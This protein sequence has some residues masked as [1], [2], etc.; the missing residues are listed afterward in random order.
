MRPAMKLFEVFLAPGGDPK[1][2]LSEEAQKET[3]AQIFSE[4]EAKLVGLEGL[5]ENET[6]DTRVFIACGHSDAQ[7]V[8]TRLEAAAGVARFKLHEI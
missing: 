3:G 1:S 4:A 8:A 6:E 5:P 2:L 7:F